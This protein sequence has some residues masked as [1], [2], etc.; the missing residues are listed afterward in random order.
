MKQF[1][2][3]EYL[4]NPERKIVTRE[5]H[6]ARVICTDRNVDDYIVIAL[7]QDSLGENIYSY[8]KEGLLRCNTE[9]PSDLFFAPE[10]KTG[11]I[12][13]S[14]IASGNAEAITYTGA[15]YPTKEE[16]LAGY[17][18]VGLLATIQIEWEE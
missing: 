1:D 10:R 14:R 12:N 6:K 8:T 2:L 4:K 5:G 7:V 3:Q 16:A 9:S 13:V 18:G 11:W 15:V 17:S